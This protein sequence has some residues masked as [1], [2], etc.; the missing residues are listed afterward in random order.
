MTGVTNIPDVA[1]IIV[2]APANTS[3]SI[4]LNNIL[5]ASG[6]TGNSDVCT[7]TIRKT[8]VISVNATFDGTTITTEIPISRLGKK[9]YII[10]PFTA[11][12]NVETYPGAVVTAT[13]TGQTILSGTA[14]DDGFCILTV[15]PGGRGDWNITST[16]HGFEASKT[17]SITHYNDVFNIGVYLSIPIFSFTPSGGDAI[18]FDEDT[19]TC[20]S[21]ALTGQYYYFRD[22]NDWEFYAKVDGTLSIPNKTAVDIFLCGAGR[23]GRSGSAD[24]REGYNS[25]WDRY[26]YNCTSCDGG[27]GGNGGDRKTITDV[28]N[29]ALTITCGASNGAAS[30]LGSL[31]SSGGTSSRHG[32]DGGYSFEDSSAKGPDGAS[33]LVGAGGGNGATSTRGDG[34]PGSTAAESGGSYRGGSGGSADASG[35]AGT[36]SSGGNGSFFGAGGGGGGAWGNYN[37]S[38]VSH[39]WGSSEGGSGYKGF[40]AFRS[41]RA[42]A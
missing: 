40:V 26:T 10:F 30:I 24:G 29:G 5:L 3:V 2:S 31:S 18:N 23:N 28:V 13:K 12:I 14:G 34:A 21:T 11:T 15:Q 36:S 25:A 38:T 37:E 27:A 16:Y 1:K 17:A 19:A 22:G 6:S 9:Y 35:G 39:L 33:R 8:G 41:I 7:L 20:G 42:T 32:A 4:L